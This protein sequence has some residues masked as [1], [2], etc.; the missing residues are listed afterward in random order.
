MIFSH[1]QDTSAEYVYT[2][3]LDVYFAMFVDYDEFVSL[4]HPPSK[5]HSNW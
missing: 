1:G 5:D 4:L 3:G 2:Q